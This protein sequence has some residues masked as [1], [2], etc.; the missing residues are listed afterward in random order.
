M[1][2]MFGVVSSQVK[3]HNVRDTKDPIARSYLASLSH[4]KT[5]II[6]LIKTYIIG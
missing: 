2:L 1:I 6:Y 3:I 5:I 4:S